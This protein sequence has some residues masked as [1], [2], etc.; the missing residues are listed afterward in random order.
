MIVSLTDVF[1]TKAMNR[2]FAR[3]IKKD[4]KKIKKIYR[5][6][7]TL[8]KALKI[9]NTRILNLY[10][11]SVLV[12]CNRESTVSGAWKKFVDDCEVGGADFLEQYL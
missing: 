9:T 10:Q 12:G 5:K 6:E 1:G 8:W 4:L 7:R 11:F 2:K 3:D